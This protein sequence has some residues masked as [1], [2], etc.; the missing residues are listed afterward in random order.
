MIEVFGPGPAALPIV[1]ATR[2]AIWIAP[3][4]F[5]THGLEFDS[6][7]GPFQVDLDVDNDSLRGAEWSLAR[8][9][10]IAFARGKNDYLPVAPCE[11]YPEVRRLWLGWVD[12]LLDAG[13]DGLDLRV[14]AHGTLTDEPEA[15]G[16]NEPVVEEYRRRHGVDIRS[17][18]HDPALLAGLRG[19]HYS[20]F[21]H[22]TSRRVRARGKRM[23]VHVHTEAFR[24]DASHGR[25]M[26]FPAN[27]RF[28]WKSWLEERLVDGITLRTSWFE[29]M[30]DP[31][32]ARSQ[33]SRLPGAL[34]DPVVEE[35]L[36]MAGRLRIPAYLNRYISRAVGL[37]EYLTDLE[38]IHR[39]PRFSGFDIYEFAG[40]ALP[41]DRGELVP[42]GQRLER[43]GK[44]ARELGL[45]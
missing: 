32:N 13:V 9:G 18:A 22:E 14:S 7:Y 36:A 17:Q 21:V 40:L 10:C 39:D 3:R 27:I 1:V 37:D 26:G 31:F 29:A 30:E 34:E 45:V 24:P 28:D 19:E 23:Q 8:G 20:A 38:R 25:L 5:R 42:V 4:S 6:G 44:K 15:Y 12:R 16:W 33:R 2:S 11:A 35:A 41:N 43:L